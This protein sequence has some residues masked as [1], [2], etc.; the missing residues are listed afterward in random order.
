MNEEVKKANDLW[1]QY[2]ISSSKKEWKTY[3]SDEKLNHMYSH[4][5]DKFIMQHSIP[6]K[7]MILGGEYNLKIFKSYLKNLSETKETGPDA[8]SKS[9]AFYLKKLYLHINKGTPNVKKNADELY[10]KTWKDLSKELKDFKAYFKQA[11]ELSQINK[12][13]F[14]KERKQELLNLIM[15]KQ[16]NNN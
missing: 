7:Q 8:W 15:E 3:N 16:K 11:K 1:R 5:F 6:A 9:Q 13:K 12:N 4:G 2:L 10:E 14:D